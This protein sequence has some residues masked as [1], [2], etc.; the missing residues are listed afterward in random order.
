MT[1]TDGLYRLSLKAFIQNEKGEVLVVK[2]TGRDWWDMPGG[3]MD[4]GETTRATL[5]RELFEEVGYTGNF[6]YEIIGVEEPHLLTVRKAWQVRL[7]FKVAPETFDFS[8][9][10]EADEWCFIDPE[11]LAHSQH[12]AEEL[13]WYYSR[14][15]AGHNPP[16]PS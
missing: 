2:E 12:L 16:I 15:R 6:T 10:K 9:G 4:A 13:V 14:K 8:V 1:A 5:Q 7:V 3:G 11:T